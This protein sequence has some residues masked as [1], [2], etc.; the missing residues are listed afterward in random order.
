MGRYL[1]SIMRTMPVT[2]SRQIVQLLDDLR[3][4][5]EVRNAQEYEDALRSL[6]NLVNADDPSPT[7]T[8]ILAIA[9]QLCSSDA[10][11]VMMTA[12]KADI[13]AVFIQTDEMRQRLLDQHSL[14][15]KSIVAELEH[16][17]REQEE[18]IRQLQLVGS[19]DTEFRDVLLSSFS[20]TSLKQTSRSD[21]SASVLFFNNRTGRPVSSATLPDAYVSENGRKV[22]LPVSNEARILPISASLLSDSESY[23]SEV[24]SDINNDISNVVDG[25]AGTYWTRDVYLS[26]PVERVSTSLQFDF[27]TGKD[28]NYVIVQGATSQPF[29]ISEMWGVAPDGHKI[30][31]MLRRATNHL[32]VSSS[33][34]DNPLEEEIE[35]DGKV[36]IDFEQVFVRSVQIKFSYSSFEESDIW[37]TDKLNAHKLYQKEETLSSEDLAPFSRDWLL[38]PEL[39]SRLSLPE[40]EREHLNG[41]KYSFGLDNV[42]FGN[43]M[44]YDAGIF[45]S[46]PVNIDNPGVV[47]VQTVERN[48]GEAKVGTDEELANNTYSQI[49]NAGSVE[50]ELIRKRL[51]DNN[52]T[53]VDHFPVPFLGQTSVIRERLVLT[54]RENNPTLLDAGLLRFTPRMSQTDYSDLKVYR[55]NELMQLG[56]DANM[57]SV[58]FRYNGTEFDWTT[59]PGTDILDFSNWDLPGKKLWILINNPSSGDVYTASYDIRTSVR[60]SQDTSLTP[61]EAVVYMDDSKTVRM[62]DDGRLMFIPDNVTQVTQQCDLYLQVTL[63]RNTADKVTSP[64]VDEFALLIAPYQ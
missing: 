47:S 3:A 45:V 30:N 23:G 31:L 17:I 59:N 11:N 62:E 58:A 55:N 54:K 10:H 35:V 39:I 33:I 57:Y 7:F 60:T 52:N 22:V 18:S 51:A 2:Q 14:V 36:R 48:T 63:R 12:A 43:G 16:I 50:Y 4:T 44:Y 53:V 9:W 27:G 37:V 64:E 29:Y 41:N 28:I 15:M 20:A 42:W 24:Q 21:P 40:V 32:D 46:K 13:E 25:T 49:R 34:L 61:E 56:G 1:K 38:S 8:Q 26:E 19:P 6:S 5:G